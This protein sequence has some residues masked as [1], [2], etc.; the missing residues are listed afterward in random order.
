MISSAYQYETSCTQWLI[1]F[2][3]RRSCSEKSD[4]HPTRELLLGLVCKRAH[5]LCKRQGR[6]FYGP[7]AIYLLSISYSEYDAKSVLFCSLRCLWCPSPRVRCQMRFLLIAIWPTAATEGTIALSAGA[8][9]RCRTD[10]PLISDLVSTQ[11]GIRKARRTIFRMHWR[12]KKSITS[13]GRNFHS[14]GKNC[15][16][17]IEVKFLQLNIMLYIWRRKKVFAGSWETF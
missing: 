1:D 17:C 11:E 13:L 8:G 14:A 7:A 2:I 4:R 3:K 9:G 6:F 16:L 5:L 12:R 15:F 10:A